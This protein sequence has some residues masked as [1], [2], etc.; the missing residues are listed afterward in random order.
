MTDE[1]QLSGKPGGWLCPLCGF[2]VV[3]AMVVDGKRYA[4]CPECEL[5]SLDPSRRPLPLDE[6]VRYASHRNSADDDG[7]RRF[8]GRLADPVRARLRPGAR[9]LDYGCGPSPVLAAMLTEAG[10]PTVGYDPVFEPHE[11][12][13]SGRYD[14]VVCSE[15]VE[16]LHHPASDFALLGQLVGAGGLLAVM[17]RFHQPDVPFA[18]WWY[19]RD[20]THV[21]FYNAATMRWIAAR[22]GWDVEILVVD[23]ALF[24][25]PPR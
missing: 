6:V 12:L 22:H 17:T 7:Y 5:V 13:L 3:P 15:V 23:I 25:V 1:L 9:G 19:R 20:S 14:F 21:C 2:G 4:L 16:H 18:T 10:Y 8:L 24:S 11:E